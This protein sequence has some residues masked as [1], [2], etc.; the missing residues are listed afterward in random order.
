MGSNLR[1]HQLNIDCYLQK[2]LYTNLI[3][4]TNQ[5][6]IIDMQQIKMKKLKYI[7]QERQQKVKES[8][9][10][11]EKNYKNTKQL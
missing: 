9:K 2:M 7:A 6:P 8:K 10:G 3:V 1:D 5:K 11:L 4:T